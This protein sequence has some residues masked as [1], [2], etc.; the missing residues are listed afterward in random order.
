MSYGSIHTQ[1]PING[2]RLSEL[3]KITPKKL[4]E[5]GWEG[6][7]VWNP[8]LMGNSKFDDISIL[9]AFFKCNLKLRDTAKMVGYKND[10]GHVWSWV[11]TRIMRCNS[12]DILEFLRM[13]MF[14][15]MLP[16]DCSKMLAK[17]ASRTPSAT[18]MVAIAIIDGAIKKWGS[19]KEACRKLNIDLSLMEYWLAKK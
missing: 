1:Y 17:R 15:E 10:A 2:A 6:L 5:K 9:S 16:T 18:K 13:L 7:M 11:N 12:S 8:H 4:R 14:A 3:A 19:K